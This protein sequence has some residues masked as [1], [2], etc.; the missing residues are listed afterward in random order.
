MIILNY[1]EQL[2]Q[3]NTIKSLIKEIKAFFNN[4]NDEEYIPAII[5]EGDYTREKGEDFY[6]KLV[7][8]HHS[9]K[10]DK[11]WLKN[12]MEFGLEEPTDY[13]N[14]INN[15]SFIHNVITQRK[16]KSRNL[17]QLN[18]LLVSEEIDEYE[19]TNSDYINA[20]YN[21]EYSN[22]KG[23]PVLKSTKDNKLLVLKKVFNHY[24]NEPDSSIYPKFELIAEFEYRTHYNHLTEDIK[25][26][27]RFDD[28]FVKVD[29]VNI[30]RLN[31][32]NNSIFVLGSI[33]IP[34]L[35]R[36]LVDKK[37]NIKVIDLGDLKPRE[38]NF[39]HYNGDTIE[40]FVCFKPEVMDVLNNYYYFYDLQMIEKSNI[41]NSYLVDVL[42]DKI[43]FWEAEYNKLPNLIKEMIDLFN[44][45][46]ANSNNII[47]KAMAAM[48]LEADWNWDKKLLPEYMLAN[49]IR[50]RAFKRAID[51]GLSFIKP[52][53][54][55]ELKEFILK[56]EA[57][58]NIY[59]ENF[60]L[61]SDVKRLINIR[62][63][64][65]TKEDPNN[66]KLLYQKYC[67]AI[68][69]EYKNEQHK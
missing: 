5:E 40:G 62:Q 51:I 12:N 58:T 35:K 30:D 31:N 47:S 33:K 44:F 14:N 28:A 1:L 4:F 42:E 29:R 2:K 59:L 54:T 16:Y 50:E 60:K 15:D 46:P 41:Q 26:V 49:Q 55:V 3:T 38:H 21:D 13:E 20:F 8:K 43:V 39:S 18:P 7:L 61:S 24:L 53:K 67:Y 10:I 22:I 25:E 64:T 11:T 68:Q 32:I 57:L 23:Y 37:R 52:N 34:L 36:N 17:Y 65:N 19:Y 6:L 66:L 45:I 9:I 69:M 56:I 63:G 48:Q 27:Y